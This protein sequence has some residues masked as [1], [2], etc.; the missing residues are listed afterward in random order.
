MYYV[1]SAPVAQLVRVTVS[2][3]GGCGFESLRGHQRC[4][5]GDGHDE[6]RQRAL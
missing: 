2:K 4:E 6:R 3:T 5:G 1:L